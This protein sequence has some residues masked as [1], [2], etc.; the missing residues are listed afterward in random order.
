MYM[1]SSDITT[2]W[3]FPKVKMIKL[4]NWKF[5]DAKLIIIYIS[6]KIANVKIEDIKSKIFLTDVPGKCNMYKFITFFLVKT[7]IMLLLSRL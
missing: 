2:L 6:P 5:P 7:K 1:P 3:K 4:G